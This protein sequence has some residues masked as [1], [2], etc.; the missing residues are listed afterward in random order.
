M[1]FPLT[2]KTDK[3]FDAVGFGLNAVDHLVVVTQYP[4]FDTKTRLTEHKQSPG[5]QT[6]TALVALQRLGVAPVDGDVPLGAEA[7]R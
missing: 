6:A 5:G 4:S 7:R 2:L 1:K 3:P